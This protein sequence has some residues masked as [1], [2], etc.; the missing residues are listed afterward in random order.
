MGAHKP[1]GSE[2]T[3]K[4]GYAYRKV[5]GKWKLIHHIIAE[6]KLG[7]ALDTQ[8]HRVS[9]ADNDRSNLHPDNIIIAEKK[10]GKLKR[11]ETIKAKISLLQEELAELE[12][13]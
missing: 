12:S 2:F 1:E 3:A 6:Q 13:H 8:V 5:D 10:G 9:F 7:H 11:I 4:N